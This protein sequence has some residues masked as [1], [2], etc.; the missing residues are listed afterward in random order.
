MDRM[1]CERVE[2]DEDSGMWLL[3]GGADSKVASSHEANAQS[4]SDCPQNNGCACNKFNGCT[5][6]K[7]HGSRSCRMGVS[8]IPPVIFI[9]SR[10]PI[11]LDDHVTVTHH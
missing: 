9:A 6:N 4:R 5:R 2:M 10:K 8:H 3:S 1:C 7:V 11:L